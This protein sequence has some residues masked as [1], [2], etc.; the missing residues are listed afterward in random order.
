MKKYIN[1]AIVAY[2]KIA[3]IHILAAYMAN[4]KLDLPFE[5]RVTHIITSR[6]EAVKLSNVAI[7]SSLKEALEI[8]KNIDI[9][10]ICNINEAHYKDIITAFEYKKAIYCEKPLT[11][12][13]EKTEDIYKLIQNSNIINGVPL[14]F[15]YL[16]CIHMLKRELSKKRFGEIIRF[17][18]KYY[19]SGYLDKSKRDTW[20]T[21]KSSGGGASIDLG[22]HMIDCI[23]YIFGE[24]MESE[25]L[26]VTYFKD[27][28]TDEIYSSKLRFKNGSIG[29]LTA[30]RVFYQQ[31]QSI[32]IEV[33]CERGSFLCEFNEPYILKCNDFYGSTEYK[34]PE[35]S[36]DFM[37][38]MV[39]ECN[40][41]SFHQDAH[42]CCLADFAR[43]VFGIEN[44]NYY[45]DF[46]QAY[47]T[48]K[49]LNL[50]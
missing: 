19:H 34:K 12:N 47:I 21:K 45:A 11:D 48:Q 35:S 13:L 23:R 26:S 4:L 33:F 30:S 41:T 6:P 7:Y 22:I 1:I 5:L 3:K 31:K 15:R 16:P 17:E 49:L 50:K 10:D 18:S 37:K 43:K 40:S 36:D 38:Y 2:G 39:D 42:M 20:R 28:E 14:I 27:T 25:N 24:P 46:K 44:G 32:Y 8:D 29:E 9:V